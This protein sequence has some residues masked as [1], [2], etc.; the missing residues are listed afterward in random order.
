[1]SAAALL[2][3]AGALAA[4]QP[5]REKGPFR[6]PELVE[7]VVLDPSLRLYIRYAPPGH[8]IGRAV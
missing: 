7:L 8:V 6:A 2:A 5:P 3:L 1:M 4:A